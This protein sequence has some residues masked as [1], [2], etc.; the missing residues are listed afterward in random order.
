MTD[1]LIIDVH[2]HVYASKEEGRQAVQATRAGS[3]ATETPM[4]PTVAMLG[5]WLTPWTPWMKPAFLEG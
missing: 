2:M 4:R 3:L 5:T 1:P